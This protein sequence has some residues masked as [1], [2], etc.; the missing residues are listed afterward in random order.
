MNLNQLPAQG[1]QQCRFFDTDGAAIGGVQCQRSSS[2]Y[3]I[4]LQASPTLLMA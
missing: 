1:K 3:I 4:D 2:M